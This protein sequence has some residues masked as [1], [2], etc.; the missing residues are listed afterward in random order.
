MP[1]SPLNV[2][3]IMTDQ[4]RADCLSVLKHPVVRTPNLDSLAEEGVLFRQAYVQAAVCG[5]SRMCFYTGRYP[6]A[7]RSP[8]N[9][10]PLP[11]DEVTMG[12]YFNRAGYRAALCGKTH[13]T[14]DPMTDPD[15]QPE[16]GIEHDTLAG[17]EA[18]ELNDGRGDGWLRYLQQQGYGADVL[19]NPFGVN[20]PPGADKD[21]SA[22]P[23]NVSR[24][25]SD[26]AFMTDRAIDFMKDAGSTPWFLHLSYFKPHLP[27][28]APYPYNE[29]YDPATSPEP[30]RIPEELEN[31]HP[32]HIPYRT[33]RKGIPYDEE[34][35]WRQ[36]R[37]TY[38][39]LITEIDDHLGRIFRYMKAHGLWENTLIVFTSDH[40]EYVG[41]HWMNEKELFYDEAYNVPFIIR[42][43]RVESDGTRGTICDRFV[44][45]V[46]VLPTFLDACGLGS[47]DPIQGC[48][49]VPLL[50]G[51]VPGDWRTA[52]H[53]DWDFR[54][55]W[56]PKLLGVAPHKCRGWMVRDTRFKYWHFNGMPDVLFDL[57]A[58]PKELHNVADRPEYAGVINEYRLE[59]L[60]WRMS[61]EDVSRVSWTYERRPGF[62]NNPFEDPPNVPADH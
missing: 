6:H 50:H 21:R 32:F 12:H 14:P 7:T 5:P 37:A 47:S 46:D 23:T 43:P 34:R 40:G 62:G 60:D 27:I 11:G 19:D 54:F 52:V 28:V 25:H 51:E 39:G 38:Y 57:V 3:F 17:L 22:Y 44:E 1:D 49:L 18:W 20:Q 15:A 58:D 30:N 42:D 13:Y 41:D 55:Y 26:T 45:S 36:R 29:M 24:E 35:V 53:A 56:S 33:E 16:S 59:L 8:W 2:L 61:N 4:M 9:E 48:S 31:P 10:V